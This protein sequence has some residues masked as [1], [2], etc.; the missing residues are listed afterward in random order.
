MDTL[1][2]S[3]SDVAVEPDRIRAIPQG[4]V[5][6][7]W[8]L[9]SEIMIFGGLIGSFILIR[10]AHGGWHAEA[11]HVHWRIGA[12][13]TLVL[14]TSSLT[15]AWACDAVKERDQR[16]LKTF[17]FLTMLLG[18]T[19]LGIKAFEYSWEISD[20]FTP[21]TNL[22]FAFYF[23]LTGLHACHVLGGIVA[24]TLLWLCAVRGRRWPMIQHRVEFAG[25]YWHFVDIVW[26]F[27][28]PLVYLS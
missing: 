16:A 9:A 5:G 10:L 4:K 8:F 6:V 7:W 1:A 27:L 3:P 28:F 23:T 11:D 17:L 2:T 21:A 13:N 19:F 24:N 12:L 25:L 18:L 15:M 14:L 20:G 22:F 26:I